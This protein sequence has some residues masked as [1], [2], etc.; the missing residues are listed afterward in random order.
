[1]S[2]PSP[3]IPKFKVWS[4][5]MQDNWEEISQIRADRSV[6]EQI[7]EDKK[8]LAEHLGIN[9]SLNLNEWFDLILGGNASGIGDRLRSSGEFLDFKFDRVGAESELF[10]A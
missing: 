5:I 8:T 4:K 1:L 10:E 7:L 3:I 9:E 2:M 6:L